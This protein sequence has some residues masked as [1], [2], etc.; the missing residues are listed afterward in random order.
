MSAKLSNHSAKHSY[1]F[2][3]NS[4]GKGCDSKLFSV[5]R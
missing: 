4:E 3:V 5:N 2:E 1:V